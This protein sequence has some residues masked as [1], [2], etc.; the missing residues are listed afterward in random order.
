MDNQLV[1]FSVRDLE[2]ELRPIA[3]YMIVN[4]IWNVVRSE[5]KKRV[6][7]IITI[8]ALIFSVI[9][10]GLIHSCYEEK[11]DLRMLYLAGKN[12]HSQKPL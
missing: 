8:F 1:C 10:I 7:S 12:Y 4:Y 5:M 11:R 9:L 6:L 3:I 2:D